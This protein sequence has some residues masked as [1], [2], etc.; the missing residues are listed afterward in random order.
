MSDYPSI[1]TSS[2]EKLRSM[3]FA[4]KEGRFYPFCR[5]EWDMKIKRTQPSLHL[6]LRH[7]YAR[8]QRRKKVRP[9]LDA[10]VLLVLTIF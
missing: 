10:A 3:V 8:S 6:S 2:H 7:W 9:F 1:H 4:D 5:R